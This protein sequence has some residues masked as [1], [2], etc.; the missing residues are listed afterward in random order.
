MRRNIVPAVAG[1]LADVYNTANDQLS[2]PAPPKTHI[3]EALRQTLARL[4]D[5]VRTTDARAAPWTPRHTSQA[6]STLLAFFD[7]ESRMLHIANTGAGRAFLGRRA[8]GGGHECRELSSSSGTRYMDPEVHSRTR[9]VDVEELVDG[10][11][12]ASPSRGELLD[13]A[14]VHVES[15]KVRDGDF[16]VLGS[17]DTWTRLG[18]DEAV[19]A[20]SG[21][22]REQEVARQEQPARGRRWQTQDR[23]L[24][25]PRRDTQGL[26]FDWVHTMVPDL[27]RD[28]DKM[29]VGTQGNPATRVLRPELKHDADG[30]GYDQDFSVT[31]HPRRPSPTSESE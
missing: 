29:S 21:C 27:I 16:L 1:S 7:S 5:D 11:W 28:V 24:D 13:A 25:F 15:I 9:D 12:S 30:S 2:A 8:A 17:H 14:S 26:G 23:S 4:D 31:V 22:M 20:V 6:A 3:D 10:G 19:Q 18:G